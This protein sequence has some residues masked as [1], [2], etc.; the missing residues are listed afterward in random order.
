MSCD[1]AIWFILR[2]SNPS[3]SYPI[4]SK[5]EERKKR[6]SE[7]SSWTLQDDSDAGDMISWSLLRPLRIWTSIG[8]SWFGFITAPTWRSAYSACRALRPRFLRE[9]RSHLA[10][11][12]PQI[13]NK[14]SES[15]V[16]ASEPRY[17]CYMLLSMRISLPRDSS[18]RFEALSTPNSAL[19]T[20]STVFQRPR[21]HQNLLIL[22]HP[23][24][25]S[26][27]YLLWRRF[28]LTWNNFFQWELQR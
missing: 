24:G 6:K 14:S 18:L 4:L 20:T 9:F 7:F 1:R 22:I 5:L 26:R 23:A 21:I 25:C 28:P 12:S 17:D 15:I 27:R 10:G 2:N 8:P 16:T 13:N 11:S 3:E 19:P